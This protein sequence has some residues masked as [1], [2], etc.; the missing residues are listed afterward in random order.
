MDLTN[1]VNYITQSIIPLES[2]VGNT[3]TIKITATLT[4]I[5]TRTLT[6]SSFVYNIIIADKCYSL[7]FVDIPSIEDQTYIVKG[8]TM[9]IDFTDFTWAPKSCA[10]SVT[11]ASTYSN[12]TDLASF[13]KFNSIQQKY[14]IYTEDSSYVGEYQITLTATIA[15]GESYEAT[16]TVT[17]NLYILDTKYLVNSPPYFKDPIIPLT[18]N[19]GDIL[20]YTLPDNADPNG[21]GI[22]MEVNMGAAAI[23]TTRQGKNFY[24]QP[25]PEA[26]SQTL[27]I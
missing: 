5:T 14:S 11:L 7:E 17:W 1:K 21:D 24:F 2:M 4:S 6:D 13:I 26:H 23:F 27:F 20:A 15:A 19:A 22:A 12:G 10:S 18:M 8:D 3:Y 9:E 25:N 16:T